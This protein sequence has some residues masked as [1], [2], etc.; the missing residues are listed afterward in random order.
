MQPAPGHEVDA[1]PASQW[2]EERPAR[3]RRGAL[4]GTKKA[5]ALSVD[6]ML[7]PFDFVLEPE[8]LAF[9]LRDVGVVTVRPGLLPVQL[10]LQLGVAGPQGLKT[11][12]DRHSDLHDHGLIQER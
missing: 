9:K 12:V 8:L 7:Q 1:Q 6:L 2:R 11:C 4:T 10:L 5:G 3:G